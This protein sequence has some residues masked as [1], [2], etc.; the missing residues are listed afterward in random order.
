MIYVCPECGDIGCGAIT[1]QVEESD[2][3]MIWRDF[4]YENNYDPSTPDLKK[5]TEVGPFWFEAAQYRQTL[6]HRW[7]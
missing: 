2:G 7:D 5:Y 1:A 6:M 3:F 4:G